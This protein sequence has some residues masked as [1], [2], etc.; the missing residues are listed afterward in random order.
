MSFLFQQQQKATRY[1]LLTSMLNSKLGH[2]KEY[3][4]SIY[5]L[6][7]ESPRNPIPLLHFCLK[8]LSH[9]FEI[10]LHI[11]DFSMAI[12]PEL[13]GIVFPENCIIYS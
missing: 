10:N 2:R 9:N 12:S 7:I 3:F 4:F 6:W 13:H 11:A 1:E 8:I 5:W